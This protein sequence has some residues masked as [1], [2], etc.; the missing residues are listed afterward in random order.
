MIHMKRH[1]IIV[2][3]TACLV[4][5]SMTNGFGGGER[6]NIRGV[7]M[8]RTFVASARGLEAIGTNPA[9]LALGDDD[10]NVTFTLVPPF[11]LSIGSDFLDY[12]IYNDFFTGEDSAGTGKR[13][14]KI[15]QPADKE[16]ILSLFPSGLAETHFD[17]D[18]RV[19]GLTI[20]NNF[21]GNI[22]LAVSERVS[23][24]FD[25][26][27]DYA[28][29]ALN[30]LDSAGSS[31]DFGGTDARAWWLREYSLSYAHTLP[32]LV[33]VKNVAAGFTVKLIHGLG[34]VGTD[35]YNATFS[36][37]QVRDVNGNFIGYR[38][39]GSF[40]FRLLR[41]G[42][43]EVVNVIEGRDTSIQ[44]TPFP[45]PA[46]SGIGVDLGVTGEVLPG[47]RAAVSVTDIGSITW[48]LN[49]KERVGNAKI[50]ITNP[51][52]KA[53]QDSL[54]QAF[55]GEE[56]E[57]GEFST[58]LATALH[59]G[60]SVQLDET[61]W[62]PWV[63]GRL[64]VAIEYQQG[65][66]KSPGNTTRPRIGVGVEYR[67]IGFLPLRTGVSI[68]GQDRFNWAMGFGFDLTYFTFDLGTENIGALFTNSFNLFSIGVGMRFKI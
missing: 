21:L 63:P 26:P 6:S 47:I 10:R 14:S 68:G 27:R 16:R 61:G 18:L 22:G 9:N 38:L 23:I 64:L 4:L 37:S 66:N 15:L 31:Y 49:T 55:K 51:T 12:E 11:G 5:L 8:G 29:F 54:E 20:H 2:V 25:M 19:F 65:F 43:N 58:S 7:S 62:A 44:F 17:L 13:I 34:Y 67:P 32:D 42:I 35:H 56:R 40:D 30:G 28:R 41:S 48:N 57:T 53:Q 60:G 39:D 1:T 45:S 50:T 59:V 52:S 3:G 46:G 24:N 36:N 33:I